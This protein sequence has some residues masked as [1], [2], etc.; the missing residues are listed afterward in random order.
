[1]SKADLQR[2]ALEA[3]FALHEARPRGKR[4]MWVMSLEWH[5]EIRKVADPRGAWLA[6]LEWDLP[7]TLL[8]IPVEI[9]DDAGFPKLVPLED[10]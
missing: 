9:R 5:Q 2:E 8:G 4:L 7:E 1:M 6:A 3:I 10:A